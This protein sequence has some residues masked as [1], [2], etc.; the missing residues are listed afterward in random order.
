MAPPGARGSEPVWPHADPSAVAGPRPMFADVHF[1][2]LK[3][4]ALGAMFA[5][6][7][8]AVLVTLPDTLPALWDA[9]VTRSEDDLPWRNDLTTLAA[10]HFGPGDIR[11]NLGDSLHFEP[12]NHA[13]ISRKLELIPEATGDIQ[14]APPRLT[15]AGADPQTLS[16]CWLVVERLMRALTPRDETPPPFR[17]VV[18][19]LHYQSDPADNDRIR[20]LLKHALG[21]Y[22]QMGFDLDHYR[23]SARGPLANRG[24]RDL[25]GLLSLAPS[26]RP[27]LSRLN[28]VLDREDQGETPPIVLERSHTDGRYFSGLYGARRDIVTEVQAGGRWRELPIGLGALAIFPGRLAGKRFGLDATIHRVVHRGKP[29]A[30]APPNITCLLGAK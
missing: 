14:L 3:P 23:H 18:Q 2:E 29:A 26:L 12:G 28:E 1:D 21:R 4:G 19:R 11:L 17:A 6:G 10:N 20:A 15:D 25:Y 24:L 9:M 8:P 22:G 13:H 30:D 7:A 27:L 16:N 5:G